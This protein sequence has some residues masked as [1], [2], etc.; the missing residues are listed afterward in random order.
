MLRRSLFCHILIRYC[1]SL[2]CMLLATTR[3][4]T[5]TKVTAVV[6]TT[7]IN[8]A[9]SARYAS[10][11]QT[12]RFH[13]AHSDLLFDLQCRDCTYEAKGDDCVKAIKKGCG[14]PKW[15][16]DGNCDDNK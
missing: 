5:G 12:K 7:T 15:K 3:V 13:V 16:G 11:T 9:R 8:S 14:A 4:A 10:L 2:R 6:P 1:I